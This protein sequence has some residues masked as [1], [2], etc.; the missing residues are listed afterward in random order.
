MSRQVDT[1]IFVANAFARLNEKAISTC[2]KNVDLIEAWPADVDAIPYCTSFMIAADIASFFFDREKRAHNDSLSL[3]ENDCRYGAN[4]ARP[5]NDLIRVAK[6]PRDDR[7]SCKRHDFQPSRE[8]VG[9]PFSPKICIVYPGLEPDWIRTVI[10]AAKDHA[11]RKAILR[12]LNVT[13][14]DDP[15]GRGLLDK[16]D[17]F[18]HI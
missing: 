18:P 15:D 7:L 1:I 5:L 12:A 8:M 3:P 9:V 17:G 6:Y 13:A 4:P 16:S 14:K 10:A 2:V 11:G